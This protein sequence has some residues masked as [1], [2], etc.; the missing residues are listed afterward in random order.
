MKKIVLALAILMALPFVAPACDACG[1]GAGS[2][3]WGILPSG[4]QHFLGF[5]ARS[6]NFIT[7][8]HYLHDEFNP[9]T[10]DWFFR[11]ELVGRL[12]M[13]KRWQWNIGIPFI[14]S[15]LG[16]LKSSGIGDIHGAL[17][18]SLLLP[19]SEA[20]VQQQF[21][22]GIG[23]EM[24]T[25]KFQFSHD[26]PSIMQPGSG[27][28]DYSLFASYSI[29]RKSLGLQTEVFWKH[30]GITPKRFQQ[31]RS[32]SVQGKI[33][34]SILKNNGKWVPSVGAAYEHWLRDMQDVD[35]N[36]SIA[37]TGGTLWNMQLGLD[38]FTPKLAVGVE[39]AH[40]LHQH[41][42]DGNSQLTGMLQCRA[43][44][45]ISQKTKK[46]NHKKQL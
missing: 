2:M 45:F 44:L 11:S 21:Q 9:G 12:A 23:G 7:Q 33:F 36:L 26:M 41:I 27:S 46:T 42:A 35:Y 25:G 16:A 37:F 40:A 4:N 24:P 22:I 28:W 19:K 8:G 17:H 29:Q 43:L 18:Y 39:Y 6:R 3:G 13:G 1:G 32:R 14:H 10:K 34:Y 5:R 15:S 38:Y 31:G 30:S 20:A